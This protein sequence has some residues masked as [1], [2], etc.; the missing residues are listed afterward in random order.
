MLQDTLQVIRVGL[1]HTASSVREVAVNVSNASAL[2]Q[3]AASMEELTAVVN[4]VEG[5]NESSHRLRASS[6]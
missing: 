2:E 6:A 4:T 3:T 5:I 1:N